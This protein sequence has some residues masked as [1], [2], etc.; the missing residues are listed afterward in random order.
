MP[1][2]RLYQHSSKLRSAHCTRQCRLVHH[3][4]VQLHVKLDSPVIPSD[5]TAAKLQAAQTAAPG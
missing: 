2:Q 1:R 3:M 4:P 5:S